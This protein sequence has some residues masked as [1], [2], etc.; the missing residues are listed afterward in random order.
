LLREVAPAKWD[1]LL[2]TS[3]L[4]GVVAIITTLVPVPVVSDLATFFSLSLFVNGPYSPLTPI[5]FEPVLM[6]YGKIISPIIVAVVGVIAQLLVE[7]VNYHLYDA[8]LRSELMRRTRES[9]M[10]ARVL[11]WYRA[12]PF[13]TTIVVAFTPLP[14]WTVRITAPLSRYP[15]SKHLTATAIGRLPRLWA[16]AALG[17]L[18]PVSSGAILGVGLGVSALFVVIVLLRRRAAARRA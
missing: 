13:L 1:R 16:Y 18:L 15:M 4:V 11:E 8:A 3:A 7:Y 5:G 10:M 6:A 12:A 14:Y 2:W 17:T 9:R